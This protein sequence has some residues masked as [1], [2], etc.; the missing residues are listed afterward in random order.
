MVPEAEV[1][2]ASAQFYAGLNQMANGNIGQ[3]REIW[4]HTGEVTTMHPIGGREVGWEAVR[5]SFEQVS[6]F[7]SEGEVGLKD[8]LIRVVGDVAYEVGVEHG[9]LK[10]A[11]QPITI[12]HRVTNIYQRF[13]DGWKLIHHHTD[14]S[15]AM[16]EVLGKLE[17]PTAQAQG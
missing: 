1:R 12:E 15:P 6:Q 7:A 10:L 14:T 4:S 11:G 9:R 5:K 13:A 3:L 16:L 2:N 17:L 8:Q